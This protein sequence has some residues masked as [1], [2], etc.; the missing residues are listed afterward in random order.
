MLPANEEIRL[1]GKEALDVLMELEFILI[2]L[3]NIGNYYAKPLGKVMTKTEREKYN[4]ETC[5][6]IDKYA[7]NEKLTKIR[8]IIAE[9]FDDELGDDDM[10]DIERETEKLIFWTAPK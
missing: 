4:K 1:T 3:R 2:S 9:K 7:I 10:D 5:D 6:F 8:R